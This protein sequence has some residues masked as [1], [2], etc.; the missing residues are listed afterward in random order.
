M[1]TNCELAYYCAAHHHECAAYH[2]KEAAKYEVAGEHE[3]AAHH[4]YLAHGHTEHAIQSDA[5]ATKLH[6]D[7]FQHVNR[8]LPSGI[9]SYEQRAGKQSAAE[10]RLFVLP[11]PRLRDTPL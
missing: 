11:M 3:K 10:E 2:Y 9:V 5:E 4:A 1:S 8:C 7:R 6:A